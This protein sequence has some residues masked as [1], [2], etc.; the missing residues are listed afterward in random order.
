MSGRDGGGSV[1]V[2]AVRRGPPVGVTTVEGPD[3]AVDSNQATALAMILTEWFTNSCKYG[4]HSRAGGGVEVRWQVVAPPMPNGPWVRLAWTER[5]G[6]PIA[7]SPL[8]SLGTELVRGFAARELRGRCEMTFPPTGV[9]HW[10][11]CPVAVDA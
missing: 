6:P 4:V 7:A 11:E 5:G 9:D 2:A 1:Q 10:L 3:V 8:P